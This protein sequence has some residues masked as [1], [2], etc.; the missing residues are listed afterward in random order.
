[1]GKYMSYNYTTIAASQYGDHWRNLR[2]IGA[3]EIFS[4]TRINT[5]SN[6]RKDE[7]KHLLLKLSQ[8]HRYY[9]YD[10]SVDKEEVRQFREIMKEVFAHGGAVNPADF[11]PV[12]NWE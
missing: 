1:M 6:I 12:L 4:S 7:V 11:L 8:K 9:G 5:F 10:V 3:I 2:L